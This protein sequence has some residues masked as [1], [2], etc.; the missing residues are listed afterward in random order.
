MAKEGKLTLDS[1]DVRAVS[2]PMRRPIVSKV[3]EYPEWPFI[4]IDVSDRPP[5]GG[6]V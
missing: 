6:P 5:W 2:I 3:G 4:L 1:I